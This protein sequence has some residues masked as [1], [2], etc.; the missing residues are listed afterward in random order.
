MKLNFDSMLETA[1]STVSISVTFTVIITRGRKATESRF[2]LC[3]L[4][5]LFSVCFVF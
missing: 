2:R 1:V 4:L 5:L 3:F